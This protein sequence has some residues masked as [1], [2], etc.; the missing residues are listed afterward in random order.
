MSSERQDKDLEQI[1]TDARKAVTSVVTWLERETIL[2]IAFAVV[3]I[4]ALLTH[5]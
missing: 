2:R 5:F 4:L 3:I 1:K